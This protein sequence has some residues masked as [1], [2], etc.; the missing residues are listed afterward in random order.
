VLPP[1]DVVKKLNTRFYLRDDANPYFTMT[2][3]TIEPATGK[4]RLVRAGHPF[5]LLQKADGAL[6]Q[7]RIEGYAVGLFPSADIFS[8]EMVLDRGDRLFLYSDGLMDCANPSGVSFG[9]RRLE[10]AIKDGRGKPLSEAVGNLREAI[11]KWRGSEIF[12]D[13]VS[14][15]A[16]E[17]V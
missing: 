5:P 9:A 17:K 4:L 2:Y 11:V 14:L 15:F 8:E 13:D 12:N 1:A 6:Q 3:A 16:L 7:V 10:D